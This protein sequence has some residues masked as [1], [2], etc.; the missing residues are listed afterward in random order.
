MLICNDSCQSSSRF[1]SWQFP[2]AA[3]DYSHC[4][5]EEGR[6]QRGCSKHRLCSASPHAAAGGRGQDSCEHSQGCEGRTW[7]GWDT[8]LLPAR[9]N[10]HR[11]VNRIPLYLDKMTELNKWRGD[12]ELRRPGCSQSRSCFSRVRRGGRQ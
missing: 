2:M 6:R 10:L 4:T 5:D 8:Q 3:C 1:L 7:L 11:R 9:G 12:T